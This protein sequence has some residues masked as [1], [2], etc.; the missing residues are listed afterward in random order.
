MTNGGKLLMCALSALVFWTG[1]QVIATETSGGNPYQAI[2]DR[3]VFGL[4]PA[5]PPPDP[6]SLKPPPPKIT[7]TGIY[8]MGGTKRALMKVQT[9]A[10]PPEPAKDVPLTLS[11][12]QRD[13]EVEVLEIDTVARTVKVKNYGTIVS[14]D[15]TNN[16]AKIASGPTPGGPPA[17]GGP[18]PGLGLPPKPFSPGGVSPGVPTAR[19]MRM[20]PTGASASPVGMRPTTTY[21]AVPTAA[22]YNAAAGGFAGNSTSGALTVPGGATTTTTGTFRQKNWPP[23]PTSPEE[24]AILEAAYTMKNKAAIERGD[25]PPVPGDNPLIQGGNSSGQSTIRPQ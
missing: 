3:N 4:K 16:G 8:T 14:L 7:L 21:S 2:V 5:P 6:E 1:T 17:P 22:T 9:P 19:P 25:M 15:F 13:G 12:G 10:K 23:E 18:G 11:E 24:A 20:D